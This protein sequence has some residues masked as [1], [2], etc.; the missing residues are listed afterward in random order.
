MSYSTGKPAYI[1][2]DAAISPTSWPQRCNVTGSFPLRPKGIPFSPG[3][4]LYHTR[5][6]KMAKGVVEKSLLKSFYGV[7][8]AMSALVYLF[9]L[10]W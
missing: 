6:G 8:Y 7:F 5:V 9:Y 1:N 10:L 2:K 3:C 4:K